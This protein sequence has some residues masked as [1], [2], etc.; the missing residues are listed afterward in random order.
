MAETHRCSGILFSLNKTQ[1][2]VIN[3]GTKLYFKIEQYFP[4]SQIYF[5][6]YLQK[7][8][9]MFKIF[10][11]WAFHKKY[12]VRKNWIWK[13]KNIPRPILKG[14][15]W[16][17]IRNLPGITL[18]LFSRSTKIIIVYP[19]LHQC[20][21]SSSGNIFIMDDYNWLYV[22]FNTKTKQKKR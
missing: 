9:Y 5:Y 10:F 2:N 20:R 21:L 14:K 3:S 6:I 7:Y 22:R 8:L 16:R 4:G 11:R 1:F 18:N 12:H 19:Q 17:C 15:Y 13:F